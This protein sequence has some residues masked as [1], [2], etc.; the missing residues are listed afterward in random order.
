MRTALSLSVVFSLVLGSLLVSPPGQAAGGHYEVD[1]IHI[2]E[3]GRCEIESWYQRTTP[4]NRLV[5]VLPTCN[6]GINPHQDM[7]LSLGITREMFG[8]E[9][10][11]FLEPGVKLIMRD[12]IPGDFGWGMALTS[13]FGDRLPKFQEVYGYIPVS[14]QPEDA[15]IINVNA[16]WEL[17]RRDANAWRWGIGG[18]YSWQPNLNLIAEVFG[19]HRGGTRWQTG[20]RY[21]FGPGL[22]DFSYSRNAIGSRDD[23]WTLGLAWA[24]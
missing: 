24:F 15:L 20:V 3:A 23:Y 4:S 17:A 5:T 22:I 14:F 1:D 18:D 2:P 12:L 13:V 10:A 7:E 11:S 21:E 16:G 6:P 19:T 9:R 8:R